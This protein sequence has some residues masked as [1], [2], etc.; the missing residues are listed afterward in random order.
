MTV[1]YTM[2]LFSLSCRNPLVS[3]SSLKDIE[4]SKWKEDQNCQ[5]DGGWSDWATTPCFGNWRIRYR[6]CLNTISSNC[7]NPCP[8]QYEVE[9]EA[10]GWIWE[11]LWPRRDGIF[12]GSV[13]GESLSSRAASAAQSR[14]IKAKVEAKIA[15]VINT[16]K[17]P[18][19]AS[20]FEKALSSVS[21]N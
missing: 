10:C 3:C 16:R 6:L 19:D 17:G 9:V 4:F 13:S 11:P 12:I 21:L 1:S 14:D 8:T 18:I 20:V 5:P 2:F 15:D 7:N